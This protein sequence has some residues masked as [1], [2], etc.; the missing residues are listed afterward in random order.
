[1]CIYLGSV[2]F[3]TKEAQ[4]VDIVSETRPMINFGVPHR[5]TALDAIANAL[6]ENRLSSGC[7]NGMG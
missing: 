3:D 6:I 5:S 1:M 2:E 4:L 7:L